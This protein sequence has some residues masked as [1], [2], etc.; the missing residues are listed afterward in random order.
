MEIQIFLAKDNPAVTAP[1]KNEYLFSSPI[2]EVYPFA[3]LGKGHLLG[4][5]TQASNPHPTSA[6]SLAAAAAQKRLLGK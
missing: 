2:K 1:P 6:A 5:G 4:A 3:F